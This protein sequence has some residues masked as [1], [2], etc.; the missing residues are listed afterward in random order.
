MSVEMSI[1]AKVEPTDGPLIAHRVTLRSAQAL[2]A[3][4]KHALAILILP[5]LG[6]AVAVALAATRGISWL[7][8]GLL[9]AMYCLTITG[10]TVGFHRFLAH[11]AFRAGPVTKAVLVILGSM[12]AQ[13]PAVYWV[14]NHRRH[15]QHSDRPGDPHSPFF[16]GETPLGFWRGLWHAH[17]GWTFG[18]ELTNA[19]VFAKD[20]L[21]DPEIGRLNQLYY[22][23]VLFG[24]AL[25][26]AVGGIV[27]MSWYGA[28]SG[29]LWGGFVRLFTTYHGTNSINSITHRFGSRPFNTREFSRNNAW[30]IFPTGG[31]AW[32]NNH[33]AFPA[34]AIFGLEWWQVDVGGIIVRLLQALGLVWD[35]KRPSAET[36]ASRRQQLQETGRAPLSDLDD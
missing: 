13:G 6:T 29:L 8:I 15:H 16:D 33:H 21:R 2:A 20:L 35:V 27:S 30:L 34:S 14:S 23:W 3:Q 7:D 5:A 25:P 26:A 22:T 4:R 10:I 31:E 9:A 36:I 24:V 1:D 32:H 28:L 11:R 17:A 12:A 19:V 18:H